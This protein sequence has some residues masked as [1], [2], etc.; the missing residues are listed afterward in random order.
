LS[1]PGEICVDVKC[2]SKGSGFIEV[3]LVISLPIRARCDIVPSPDVNSLDVVDTGVFHVRGS[4]RVLMVIPTVW[5]LG[6]PLILAD[7]ASTSGRCPIRTR[8]DV[9]ARATAVIHVDRRSAMTT[10]ASITIVILARLL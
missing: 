8:T 2:N 9:A 6:T 3:V 5:T 7:I 4:C 1:V 10:L